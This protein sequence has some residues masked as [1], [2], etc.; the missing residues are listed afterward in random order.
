MTDTHVNDRKYSLF[1]V[2]DLSFPWFDFDDEVSMLLVRLTLVAVYLP[3]VG[4]FVL[5]NARK[6]QL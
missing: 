4:R 3:E 5:S 1:V 6:G 2:V